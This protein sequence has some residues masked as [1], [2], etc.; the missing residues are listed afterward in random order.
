MCTGAQACPSEPAGEVGDEVDGRLTFLLS[1]K[2][3]MPDVEGAT[4]WT[5]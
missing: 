4:G 2:D 1:V 3:D 5:G